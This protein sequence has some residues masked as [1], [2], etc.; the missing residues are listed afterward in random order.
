MNPWK[1]TTAALLLSLCSGLSCASGQRVEAREGDSIET[2]SKILIATRPS[3]FKAKVV[4]KLRTNYEQ[5]NRLEIIE[6]SDLGDVETGDYD[7]LVVMG[8]RMGWLMFSGREL[9]FLRRLQ[10][11]AKLV[12]VMTAANAEWEWD[13]DDVDVITCASKAENVE[14]LYRDVSK[15]LDVLLAR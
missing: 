5:Q 7:A 11:P 1:S 13:R 4:S 10:H 9:A 14:P 2:G 8:A 12:M 6:L 15:R 3:E